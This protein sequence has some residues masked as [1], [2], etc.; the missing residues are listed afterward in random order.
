MPRHSASAAQRQRRQAVADY[1]QTARRPLQILAFLLPLIIAY[2][3]ALAFVL[4][5]GPKVLSVRAH[6]ALLEFFHTFGV[7]EDG[8]RYGLYLGGIVILVV[9]LI[10][11]VLNRD[12]WHVDVRGLGLM[13]L[14]AAAL[15]LPLLLL[16]QLVARTAIDAGAPAIAAAQD[17]SAQLAHLSPLARMAISVGAGL[18]EELLFRMLLIALLHALLVDVG[19]ASQTVGAAVAVL[20]SAA[21]FTWYHPLADAAGHLV[22]RKLAFYFLAGLYFGAIYVM[23]GFGIVVVV[24]ALYDIVTVLFLLDT[25]GG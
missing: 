6:E 9:L 23:R 14:E 15:T 16:G 13:T 4:R 7:G 24:H 17:T 5:S 3:L 2:E 11:H 22:L 20:I 10:W 8:S 21:L 18:Y 12:P 1:W 25:S 19:R